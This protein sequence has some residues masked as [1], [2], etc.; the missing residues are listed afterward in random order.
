MSW[1][2]FILLLFAMIYGIWKSSFFSAPK[3]KKAHFLLAFALK[4]VAGYFLLWVYSHH[5]TNRSEA[6][7]FKYF[8]DGKVVYDVANTSTLDY[9][10]LATG[11]TFD[12]QELTKKHLGETHFWDQNPSIAWLN[13]N[14]F[15]IRFHALLMPISSG[16]IYLHSLV[17]IFLA[18]CGLT[19]LMHFLLAST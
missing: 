3:L 12:T 13:D 4:L 9:L 11:L 5:Y 17:A 16:N 10:K 2:L 6:D 14:R 7:V 19:F 15:M 1:I 18:F 8:D